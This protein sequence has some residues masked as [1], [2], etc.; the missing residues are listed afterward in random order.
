MPLKNSTSRLDMTALLE[1]I[2]REEA[3]S[4]LPTAVPVGSFASLQLDLID[5]N[6]AITDNGGANRD[7][8]SFQKAEHQ[9]KGPATASQSHQARAND[10][11]LAPSQTAASTVKAVAHSTTPQGSTEIFDLLRVCLLPKSYPWAFEW[12]LKIN[13]LSWRRASAAVMRSLSSFAPSQTHL[14]LCYALDGFDSAAKRKQLPARLKPG[15]DVWLPFFT[16]MY[17]YSISIFF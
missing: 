5:G 16:P 8:V 10:N 11:E 17:L 9:S 6:F 7:C 1:V 15:R 3:K 4:N 12:T 14:T 2:E 13:Q